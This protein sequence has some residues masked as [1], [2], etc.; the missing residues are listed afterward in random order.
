M[1]YFWL[2]AKTIHDILISYWGYSSFRSLQEEIITSVIEGKDTLALLPTGG[3]KSVCFQVPGLFFGGC[4]IVVSPL[5]ALMKDQVYQLKKRGINAECLVSGMSK[6]AIDQALDNCIYGKTQ[7][8]YVSP[9][10]LKTDIFI[11][12]FKKMKLALIAIDE[13]HCISEWGFDFRPP[14]LEIAELRQYQPQCTFLAL[15][16]SATE[17]VQEEIKDKLAFAKS[18]PTF[19]ASFSRPNLVYALKNTANK[20]SSIR[21][22]LEKT[23]GT[24]ILYV[25]SRGMCK[26]LSQ[27]LNQMG[28]SADFY[29]AGLSNKERNQKQESWIQGQTR[30]IVATN[31]FGMGI[32]KPDVRLVLHYGFPDSLEAYYQEAGRGG[33]DGRQSFALALIDDLDI[34]NLKKEVAAKF[35]ALPKIA[36]TYHQIGSFLGIPY[37]SGFEQ[38]FSFDLI[39]FCKRFKLLP[40]SVL[41]HLGL[42]E[43][44]G[45]I[46]FHQAMYRPARI[47]VRLPYQQVYEFM[48]ANERY[49]R[50]LKFIQ[51]AYEGIYEDYAD[52]DEDQ[53]EQIMREKKSILIQ[54]LLELDKREIISYR[55]QTR[56]PQLTYLQP[57][58]EKSYLKMSPEFF[59]KRKR[60]FQKRIDACLDYIQTTSCRGNN[61]LHYF[62]ES[63]KEP[64]GH[65]DFCK[66]EKIKIRSKSVWEEIQGILAESKMHLD[67]FKTKINTDDPKL[68]RLLREWLSEGKLVID[69]NHIFIK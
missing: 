61:I 35:P 47:K 4:T 40:K 33:R 8:L 58:L 38:S 41:V 23:S 53:M 2:V 37:G 39:T 56:L 67:V 46:Y 25:R 28:I 59:D 1:G 52:I 54:L 14:Y 18:S 17:R 22:A 64:C 5:I 7:F 43:Q 27:W 26:E 10:R 9:E 30:V 55:P 6:T 42:L 12:R 60:V 11:E 32:D 31:A 63:P 57:R 29:H 16:A 50:I 3:G 13:A 68:R 62:D 49:E 19:R 20:K 36:Q 48:V 45:Y 21:Y 51:R 66:K 15:T 24:A 44:S 65:C 69:E 34:E